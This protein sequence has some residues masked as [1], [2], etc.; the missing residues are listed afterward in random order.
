MDGVGH[1]RQADE[2]VVDVDWNELDGVGV[3]VHYTR[4]CGLYLVEGM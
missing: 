4:C 3:V 1:G 2:V